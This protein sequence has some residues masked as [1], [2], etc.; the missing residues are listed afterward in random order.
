M[1]AKLFQLLLLLSWVTVV[2]ATPE[3]QHWQTE[4]GTRV[5]FVETH[6][7]PM[8]DIQV[9]FDAGSGRDNSKPGLAL[10][11]NGLLSDGAA[12]MNA[13][14]I[15][16]NFEN[17]GAVYAS[18]ASID[19]ASVSLRVMT[20]EEKLKAAI[21]NLSQVMA[22]PDFPVAAFER[23]RKRT[24]VGIQQKQQS[25]GE[26]ANDAFFTAVYGDHPYAQPQEGTEISLQAITVKDIKAFHH[27]YYVTSNAV[28][29][30][31]G[32][33][34]RPQAEE[35][36]KQLLVGLETGTPAT[37]LPEVQP[38][39]SENSVR[40][41]HPSPQ[42]HVLVGQPGIMRTDPDL[43]PVY[44]GNEVLGGGSMVSRLF[45]EIREKRGLSYSVY[46]YF[47]P[48][49]QAG[50]FVAGLQT[51]TDQADTALQLLLAELRKFI[52]QGPT[53]AEL[54]AAKKNL[55]G[56]FPL[57]IDSNSDIINYLSMIGFYNL[58]LDYLDTYNQKIMNV[59]AEQIRDAFQRK[60]SPDKL[61]TVMVGPAPEAKTE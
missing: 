1:Y 20:D 14:Q 11:T 49:R 7:L 4:Q 22:K 21:T 39:A 59:T 54:K 45:E 5:Y 38:L 51:R 50:P 10:L 43:F 6:E 30:L 31:V 8:V 61:V 2:H 48:M 12:G 3:I 53:P 52:E 26:L 36:V 58:P 57:R 16:Q 28:I 27:Q 9:V 24:L 37:P 34:K 44:V 15:S 29:A 56:G 41:E 13:D 60:L 55:T 18:S 25:P 40:I 42:T 32:D 23:E 33:L 46:S 19:S 35:L 47:I 17:I